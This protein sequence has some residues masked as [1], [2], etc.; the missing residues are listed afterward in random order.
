MKRPKLTAIKK[1]RKKKYLAGTLWRRND[2]MDH[3][4]CRCA[5]R[6]SAKASAARTGYGLDRAAV[7]DAA[8][9]SADADEDPRTGISVGDSRCGRDLPQARGPCR[10]L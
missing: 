10:A 7:A 6:T 2:W 4:A 3:D 8:V 1:K 5:E 9:E